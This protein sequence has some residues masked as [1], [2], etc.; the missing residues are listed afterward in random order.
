VNKRLGTD[1]SLAA[2]VSMAMLLLNI[3]YVRSHFSEL[4]G[5]HKARHV[6]ETD[7]YRYI[8]MALGDGARPELAREAPFCWRVLVPAGARLLARTGLDLN[9]AFYVITNLSL[10]GFL[11]TLFLFLR[12]RGLSPASATLGIVLTGLM[13]GAVRWY[14][15][16]YWMTDPTCL[17]LVVVTLCLL[18]DERMLPAA[19]TAILAAFTRET[20]VI[21]FPFY[22]V[23]TWRKRS[24]G[25]A[26]R[27]TAVLAAVPLLVLVLLRAFIR[28][29]QP[30][31]LWWAL[32]DALSF[33]W[34]HLGDNQ[35]Y[36][37]TVGTWGVLLPLVLLYPRRLCTLGRQHPEYVVLVLSVY[38]TLAVANNTERLL[39][40]ALP[41]VLPAGLLSL[42]WLVEESGA[43]WIALAA[44]STAAQ[45]FFFFETRLYEEGMSVYQPSNRAVVAVMIAFWL[46][47]RLIASIGSARRS[48]S[49]QRRLA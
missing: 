46:G 30:D 15:Y 44:A 35:P 25:E 24:L 7:Q 37:L 17:L 33:R 10:F 12:R 29:A 39:A 16:Q 41:A 11:V 34:R 47:A 5:L 21:I 2:A 40:Y 8:E 19:A 27:R 6:L 9:V 18:Q 48:R 22:F 1:V 36:V 13:Q 3:G 43:L 4:H 20:S 28:P 38:A 49:H 42:E 26:A 32:A 45:A 23:R 31:N 14:E